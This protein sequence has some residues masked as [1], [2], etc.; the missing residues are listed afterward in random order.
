MHVLG[1]DI[2]GANLKVSDG[3]RRSIEHPFPLW[4]QPQELAH[5][6]RQLA[7]AFEPAAGWAITMTGELADCFSTKREGVAAILSAVIEAANGLPV[8]VW[9]TSGE[10]V[11]VDEAK[12]WPLLTA[13]SNWLALAT[14]SGRMT[15]VGD[16]LLIDTGSTT[17]DIIPLV[18]GFPSPTGRTDVERLLSGELVYTGWKRTPVVAIANQVRLRGRDSPLAAELFATALDVHLLLERVKETD[19]TDTANGRAATI[20]NAHDRLARMLCCDRDELSL[21]EAREI[22]VELAAR[23]VAQISSALRRVVDAMNTP[24]VAIVTSGSGEFLARRAVEQ[25][26]LQMPQR[27]SLNESLGRD[28]AA[29]ACAFALARLAIERQCF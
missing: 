21:E 3:R 16:A 25:C 18:D 27:L 13:A 6:I 14:W 20:A 8:Q 11:E 10:F 15:P 22:A 19:E 2:G 24:P 4:K 17:T 29:A 9:T 1:W 28:H 7:G 5:A 26:G 23:Q 12:E